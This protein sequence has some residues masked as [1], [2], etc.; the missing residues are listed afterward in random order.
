[1]SNGTVE[2]AGSNGYGELGDGTEVGRA[3]PETIPNLSNVTAVSAGGYQSLFLLS[4]GTVMASGYDDEDQLG[5]GEPY[6]FSHCDCTRKLVQVK[7]VGGEGKLEHVVAVSAGYYDS[8]ALLSDGHVVDWG[9]GSSGELG[10]GSNSE[11]DVPV[12]VSGLEG[13]GKLEDVVAIAAGGYH[14]LALLANGTVVS[15]GYNREGQLG[16][17]STS[18]SDVPV[19]VEGVGGIGT[20]TGVQS[21][22]ANLYDSFAVL[23]NGKVVGW[24]YNGYGQL[25]DGETAQSTVPVEVSGIGGEGTL[26]GV[27]TVSPGAET[28]EALLD[29]GTLAGWGRNHYGEI[30]DGNLE[31]AL[32]P[33]A[34]PGLSGLLTLAHGDYNY[35]TIVTQGASASLSSTSLAFPD[36][37]VGTSSAEETITLKNSG[38]AELAVSGET[39]SGAGATSFVKGADTC[40]G[41]TL[42]AGG[43]CSVSIAFKPGT[44]GSSAATLAFSTSSVNALPTVA[45]S[46]TGIAL[47]A[48]SLSTVSLSSSAFRAA[49]SGATI[50]AF[51]VGTSVLYTDS[52]AAQSTFQVQRRIRGVKTAGHC[53]KPPKKGKHGGK[54]RSC[55][56]WPTVGG[57]THSDV[58]GINAFRFSGRLS[59]HAL[60]PGHYRLLVRAKASGGS[61]A[62]QTVYFRILR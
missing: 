57:F 22:A 31:E 30:G 51:K 50:S 62:L 19:Q 5:N 58:A 23:T 41:A 48:P 2:G 10:N 12:E 1:M 59:S 55:S 6:E 33:V 13:E 7:A 42:A 44:T 56:Y 32:S 3:V 53:V 25:G 40:Q 46:G 39:I 61:S 11:S 17:E 38:P 18:N 47:G 29:N 34:V 52:Q 54:L 14:N 49:P 27:A 15:W 4:N 35:D 9:Y 21:I 20:L 26:E 24:G 43:T 37:T 45:L 16:D 60:A 28:T 8:V 36:Q